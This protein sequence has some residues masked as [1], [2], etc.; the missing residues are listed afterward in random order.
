MHL[1]DS[2]GSSFMGWSITKEVIVEIHE[3]A[4]CVRHT[5]DLD[6]VTGFD[7]A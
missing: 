7:S 5:G 2:G 6:T 1:I 3:R 4:C